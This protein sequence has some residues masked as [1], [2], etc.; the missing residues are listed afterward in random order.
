[1]IG[2]FRRGWVTYICHYLT[3]G[4]CFLGGGG[5]L[6]AKILAL[7]AFDRSYTPPSQNKAGFTYPAKRMDQSEASSSGE[8]EAPSIQTDRICGNRA[9]PYLG[10]PR[11]ATKQVS[12]RSGL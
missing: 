10:L 12:G 2:P 3:I 9:Q 7:Y 5:V 8:L 1:M 6:V 4:T 11:I